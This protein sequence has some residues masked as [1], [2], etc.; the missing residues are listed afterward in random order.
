MIARKYQ[1]GMKQQTL[2]AERNLKILRGQHMSFG[3]SLQGQKIDYA[4]VMVEVLF[5]PKMI[6]HHY[7]GKRMIGDFA[8]GAGHAHFLHSHD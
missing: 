7:Q 1:N 6:V 3:L 2:A 5:L 4:V 8:V